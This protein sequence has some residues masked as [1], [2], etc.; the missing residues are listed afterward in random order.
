MT[1]FL[2]PAVRNLPFKKNFL[3]QKDWYEFEPSSAYDVIIA[4][5]LFPN[6]DQRLEIFLNRY[7]PFCRE[8]RLTLTF[9]NISRWYKVRRTDADEVFHMLAWDGAQLMQ[10]LNKF[11]KQF[12]LPIPDLSLHNAPSLYANQRHIC[13]IKIKGKS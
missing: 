3:I 2:P 12:I 5:D 9:Y 11:S 7:L 8:M 4:N 1:P 13:Y 6:V 10:T